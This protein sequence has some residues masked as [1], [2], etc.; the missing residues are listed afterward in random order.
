[1]GAGR[2][3]TWRPEERA[4]YRLGRKLFERGED[5]AALDQLAELCDA[6]PEFADVHYMVGVLHERRGELD[7][8][9][10]RLRAALRINPHYTEARLALASVYEQRGDFDRSVELARTAPAADVG[11]AGGLDPTTDAKLANLQAAL[12]DAYR[13]AGELADAVEAYRKALAR[14]PAFHDVRYRLAV[15]LRERGLAHQALREFERVLRA[16]PDFT[17]ARAQLGLTYYTLGQW[18]RAQGLWEQC[19]GDDPA[20]EDV[21]LYLQLRP[22]RGGTSGLPE[23]T[24]ET[25]EPETT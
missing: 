13:E 11:R 3:S 25:P 14:R 17:D 8:A 9:E 5:G 19:V 22:P 7:A 12:G 23:G 20:R 10:D 18:S 24:S 2:A 1:M 16:N 6:K 4:A 15:T 21:R